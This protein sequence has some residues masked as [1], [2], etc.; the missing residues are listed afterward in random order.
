MMRYYFDLRDGDSSLVD[1]VGLEL[2]NLDAAKMEAS[3]R[4]TSFVKP[5]VKGGE[6]RAT[7][8]EI[9]AGNRL[10]FTFKIILEKGSSGRR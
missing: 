6:R 7:A 5:Y 3:D 1:H 10:V 9:R 8:I 4:L 2:A